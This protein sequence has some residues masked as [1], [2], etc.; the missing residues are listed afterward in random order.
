MPSARKDLLSICN[1]QGTPLDQFKMMFCDRCMQEECTRSRIGESRF[2]QRVQNWQQNLFVAPPRMDP[3]DPRFSR[4]AAQKFLTID[5]GP[6]SEV[7]T[8]QWVDPRD[9]AESSAPMITPP[10]APAPVTPKLEVSQPKPAPAVAT[11]T[12]PATRLPLT[13]MN[14]PAQRGVMIGD[15][16]ATKAKDPWAPPAP[17]NP[18][19]VV[20]TPG[21][22]VTV[23]GKGSGPSGV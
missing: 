8:N 14:T 13:P 12:V 7:R 19:E 18:D 1:D 2:E 10:R 6:I 23:G 11:Q 15:A 16:P 22:K 9:L 5:S 4:I 3:T 17:A 21:A 20:L